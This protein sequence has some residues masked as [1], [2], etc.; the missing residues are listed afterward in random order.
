M[1]IVEVPL[2]GGPTTFIAC[3]VH[4][5]Y[6]LAVDEHAVFYSTWLAEGSL[7]RIAKP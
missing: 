3:D 2:A 6:S 4:D 1:K 7:I 5:L